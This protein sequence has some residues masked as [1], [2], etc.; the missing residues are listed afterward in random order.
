MNA[1]GAAFEATRI[2]L[3][4]ARRRQGRKLCDRH[5]RLEAAIVGPQLRIREQR[6]LFLHGQRVA[7]FVEELHDLG[8]PQAA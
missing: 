5:L 1:D 4:G 8:D 3:A 7:G 6:A 2:D